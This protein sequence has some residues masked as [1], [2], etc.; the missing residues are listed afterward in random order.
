MRGAGGG[1]FFS[2]FF[3]KKDFLGGGQNYRGIVLHGGTNY[4]IVP[5]GRGVSQNA[6]SSNPYIFFFFF[7]L[8]N[9]SQQ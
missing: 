2:F 6:F 5:R 4:Q 8:E 7:F 1:G 3:S 9:F